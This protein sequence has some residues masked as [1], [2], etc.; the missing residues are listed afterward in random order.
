MD[1]MKLFERMGMEAIKRWEPFSYD[2]KVLPQIGAEL[3]EKY[4]L[5]KNVDFAGLL[6][7][8]IG[9]QHLDALQNFTPF[10]DCQLTLFKHSRLFVEVLH[11]VSGTTSIHDHAFTGCFQLVQG[12][13]LHTVYDFREQERVNSRFRIG[14]I[15]FRFA[16]RLRIGDIRPIAQG[17]DFIHAAFHLAR[18][19]ISV[20]LRTSQNPDA[21]PQ[22]EYRL[23][24][25]A[26]Q[27]NEVDIS[28]YKRCNALS[29]L[30]LVNQGLFERGLLKLTETAAEDVVYWVARTL[31]FSVVGDDFY[32]QFNDCMR[33]RKNGDTLAEVI[34]AEKINRKLVN[35]RLN[36]E[37]EHLQTFIAAL[38]NIPERDKMLGF[39]AAEIGHEPAKCY[40]QDVINRIRR[41]L[42][43]DQLS[44]IQEQ[45][46]SDWVTSKHLC[47]DQQLVNFSNP[48]VKVLLDT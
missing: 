16:E 31:D 6:H 3:F 42:K 7:D 26:I 25:L 30:R 38:L 23:P 21:L 33:Q 20:V 17:N 9:R 1:N 10:S 45:E 43:Q 32:D 2:E 5:H 8:F 28:I 14:D 29:I 15:A 18:P 22:F 48:L 11:W 13:S 46:I 47:L 19:S 39:L 44:Q 24:S 27:P 35:L 34:Q 41:H 12:S 40:L 36:I 37:E 4:E